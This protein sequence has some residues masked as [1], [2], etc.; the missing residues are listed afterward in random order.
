MLTILKKC[1]KNELK[2]KAIFDAVLFGS[3]VKGKNKP[4][5]IDFILIHTRGS[6]AE[7]LEKLQKIKTKIRAALNLEPL[8][9]D[10][11]TILLEELFQ[12]GFF[13]RSGVFL[14][15]ISL[16]DGKPL[17]EKMG[18][19]AY[20]LFWY[21]LNSLSHTKKV[22]FNYLLAGRGTLKGMI[23]E[24]RGERLVNGAIKI[25]VEKSIEFEDVLRMHKINYKK[26][27]ILEEL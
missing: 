13:A 3:A 5:D 2:D 1:L 19:K 20:S 16:L 11:H 15:G 10:A 6:L 25:P 27:N 14:E 9:L 7:R 21:T 4:R 22:S 23:A 12:P 24:C 8:E 17:A 26:K 18:F